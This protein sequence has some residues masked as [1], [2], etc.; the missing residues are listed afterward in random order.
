MT[1]RLLE[2]EE[3]ILRRLPPSNPNVV[4]RRYPYQIYHASH[5]ALQSAGN[6]AC[7]FF[8]ESSVQPTSDVKTSCLAENG[9]F[10]CP[11]PAV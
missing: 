10:L 5:V 1:R 6:L 9:Q 11:R 8:D 3:A 2:G 7:V 4:Y